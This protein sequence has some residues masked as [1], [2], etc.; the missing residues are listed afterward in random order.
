MNGKRKFYNIRSKEVFNMEA[1]GEEEQ[2][3]VDKYIFSAA[4]FK[5]I[6]SIKRNRVVIL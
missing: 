1:M 3:Y 6:D 2:L 5:K 4:A